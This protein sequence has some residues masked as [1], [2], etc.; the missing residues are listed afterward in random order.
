MSHLGIW[1]ITLLGTQAWA[2][3][4]LSAFTNEH[5]EGDRLFHS[6]IALFLFL[7]LDIAVWV[8]RRGRLFDAFFVPGAVLFLMA[9]LPIFILHLRTTLLAMH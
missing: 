9:L 4:R 2:S 1:V 8:R 5:L 7:G 3:W 6:A